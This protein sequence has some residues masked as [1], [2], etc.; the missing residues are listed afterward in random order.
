MSP[1]EK[2][3]TLTAMI[4]RLGETPAESVEADNR[5]NQ[6]KLDSNPSFIIDYEFSH[7]GRPFR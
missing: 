4:S 5:N 3:P 7:V 1:I 6:G 2:Q